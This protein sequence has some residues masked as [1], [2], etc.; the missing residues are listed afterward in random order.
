MRKIM[1]FC[2]YGK[3][4][5]LHS[6][7]SRIPVVW[8]RPHGGG[9]LTPEAVTFRKFCMSKWK[10]LDPWGGASAEHADLDPSIYDRRNR[11]P[12]VWVGSDLE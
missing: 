1:E 7:G 12:S 3:V 6:G 11:L 2:H 10:N 8:R 9:A 4:G 5:I